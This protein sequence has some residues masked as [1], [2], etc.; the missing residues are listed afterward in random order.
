[1][2]L[3]C[4]T[5]ATLIRLCTHM[6]APTHTDVVLGALN[7]CG[8]QAMQATLLDAELSQQLAVEKMVYDNMAAQAAADARAKVG[9]RLLCVWDAETR[10]EPTT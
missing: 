3:D 8:V 2:H 7:V 5:H 1:M 6:A 10:G 4:C 9:R